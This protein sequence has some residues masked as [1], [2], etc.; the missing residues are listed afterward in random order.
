MRLF[1]RLWRR[2]SLVGAA[3]VGAA[4]IAAVRFASAFARTAP[5]GKSAGPL[6]KS[7]GIDWLG[8]RVITVSDGRCSRCCGRFSESAESDRIRPAGEHP[9]TPDEKVGETTAD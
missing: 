1:S 8:V 2:S 3:L 7:A 4:A 6:G 5:L 9:V